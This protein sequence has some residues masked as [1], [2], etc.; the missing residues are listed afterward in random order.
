M[1]QAAVFA[2]IDVSK[3][4]LQL[5]PVPAIARDMGFALIQVRT[6]AAKSARDADFSQHFRT[7]YGP[8]PGEETWRG[9]ADGPPLPASGPSTLLI[10]SS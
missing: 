6:F 1:S 3:A 7:W 8:E 2:G 4:E 5:A 10:S 9:N